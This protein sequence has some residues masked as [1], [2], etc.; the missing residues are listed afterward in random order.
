MKKYKVTL[1]DEEMT[2][3][4]TIV[5]KGSHKSQKLLNALILLN[6]NEIKSAVKAS[7]EQISQILYVSM[8]KIDRVKQR[9]VAGGL[10]IAI[11]G[12]P[13]EREYERKIDGELEAHIIA[14]SCSQ[15]P[16]GFGRWSLRILADKVVELSYIES[17]SHETVRRVLKKT[18][19]SRGKRKDG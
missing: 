17:I 9:F 18:N 1:S 2:K 12:H 7:N 10:E 11:D 19:L 13:K 3:L 6:S 16:S 14:L 5:S 15:A 8:R 4:E